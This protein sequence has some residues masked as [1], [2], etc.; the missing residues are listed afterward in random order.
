MK[1]RKYV[2]AKLSQVKGDLE[3]GKLV[4]GSIGFH[5]PRQSR[6]F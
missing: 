6:I 3:R 5:V 4:S 1:D 2:T